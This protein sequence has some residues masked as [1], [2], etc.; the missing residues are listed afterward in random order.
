[1]RSRRSGYHFWLHVRVLRA[2]GN[3][4]FHT[5]PKA[6]C[7]LPITKSEYRNDRSIF[8]SQSG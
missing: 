7:A 1:M 6:L 5:M 8:I 4:S 2:T 3:S